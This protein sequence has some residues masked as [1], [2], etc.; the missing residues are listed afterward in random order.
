MEDN[1]VFE[2][3]EDSSDDMLFGTETLLS[4][5]SQRSLTDAALTYWNLTDMS[6]ETTQTSPPMEH[7]LQSSSFTKPYRQAAESEHGISKPT[8]HMALYNIK[9]TIPSSDQEQS[10]NP[11]MAAWCRHDVIAR[12]EKVFESQ[13]DGLMSV[14]GHLAVTLKTRVTNG[15]TESDQ[16]HDGAITAKFKTQTYRY[17][18]KS[19]PESW[20]YSGS[21]LTFLSRAGGS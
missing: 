6:I 10:Q 9:E 11:G 5:S 17:P 4:D 20:R 14:N 3:D 16:V 8:D 1:N 19:T 13:I 12:I 18:G 15:D 21:I 7:L 2:M